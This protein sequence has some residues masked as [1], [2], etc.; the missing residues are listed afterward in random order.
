MKKLNIVIGVIL[1]IAAIWAI[2]HS[3]DWH[4]LLDQLHQFNVWYLVFLFVFSPSIMF[5]RTLRW[6]RIISRH[7][8]VPLSTIFLVNYV[9]FFLN[10]VL[11]AKIGEFARAELLKQKQGISRGYLLGTVFAE[12]LLDSVMLLLFLLFSAF[13]SPMVMNIVE[14]NKLRIT[15][16]L[17]AFLVILLLIFNRKL[18][19]YLFRFFPKLEHKLVALHD[20]FLQSM[21]SLGKFSTLSILLIETLGIWVLS[22][23]GYFLIAAAMQISLPFYAYSFLIAIAAFG[24]IIPSGPGNIGVYH[25]IIMIALLLFIPGQNEKAL[26]FALISHAMSFSGSLLFG[27]VSYY[28]L[29]VDYSQLRK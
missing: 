7:H 18:G 9:G 6:K 29:G 26:S 20:S 24:M 11:P 1:S 25:G 14:A 17:A 2:A 23:F 12:R 27:S 4:T 21:E 16:F 19:S 10:A 13:C 8:T 28:L 15:V 5:V 3:V 22:A